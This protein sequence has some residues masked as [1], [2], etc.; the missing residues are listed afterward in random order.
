MEKL[1][2]D[3]NEEIVRIC[4]GSKDCFKNSFNLEENGITFKEWKQE[5][6]EKRA[7]Q[8]TFIGSKDETFGN[9]SCTYDLENHLTNS[10]VLKR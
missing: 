6:E 1:E 2:S 9:Q 4:F 10:S 8:F 7:A 3:F 5:W